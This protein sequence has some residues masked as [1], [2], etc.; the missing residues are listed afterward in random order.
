[1]KL[2]DK[3]HTCHIKKT[4]E[5]KQ[6]TWVLVLKIISPG[7]H[8]PSL[9]IEGLRWGSLKACSR[10]ISVI[11]CGLISASIREARPRVLELLQ[12]TDRDLMGEVHSEDSPTRSASELNG[13]GKHAAREPNFPPICPSAFYSNSFICSPLSRPFSGSFPGPLGPSLCLSPSLVAV[14]PSTA[15]LTLLTLMMASCLRCTPLNS[16]HPAARDH[17]YLC[18]HSIWHRA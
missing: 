15:L 14:R 18:L 3:R 4:L 7:F 5:R 16:K 9:K 2:R 10:V 11:L 12:V 6:G 17:I 8:L 1:M 13:S